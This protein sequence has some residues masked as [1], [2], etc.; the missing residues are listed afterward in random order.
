MNWSQLFSNTI[1]SMSP[2]RAGQWRPGDF[3]QY[4]PDRVWRACARSARA[5]RVTAM[6]PPP[7]MWR[8]MSPGFDAA[9]GLRTAFLGLRAADDLGADRSRG[10]R[11][12]AALA[13]LRD[14]HFGFGD[15][16]AER[17]RLVNQRK[18][19]IARCSR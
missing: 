3:R 11:H 15:G 14:Q 13:R 5:V 16:R 12:D 6:T 1:R 4:D 18:P 9:L 19:P 2:M 10:M 17:P 8:A 7:S